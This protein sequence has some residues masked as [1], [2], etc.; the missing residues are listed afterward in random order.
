MEII[1]DI[2]LGIKI[3]TYKDLDSEKFVKTQLFILIFLDWMD[4]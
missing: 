4:K 1:K 3:N 2:I